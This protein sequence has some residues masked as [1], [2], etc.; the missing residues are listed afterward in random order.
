MK[1]YFHNTQK[2]K[3][4][5]LDYKEYSRVRA[6]WFRKHGGRRE[7]LIVDDTGRFRDDALYLAEDG[8]KIKPTSLI[9]Q[10]HK[11]RNQA[12]EEFYEQLDVKPAMDEDA[13]RIAAG[14]IIVDVL[15]VAHGVKALLN[16]SGDMTGPVAFPGVVT[17]TYSYWVD[18]VK[19]VLHEHLC[20]DL[21]RDERLEVL[22]R[23]RDA[24]RIID[25]G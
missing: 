20:G 17:G 11:N 10:A 5:A 23:V 21:T 25:G 8:S 22:T 18:K 2:A 15:D 24:A 9:A 19:R 14:K 7:T 3:D 13:V 16:V 1:E 4:L 6:A 12:H